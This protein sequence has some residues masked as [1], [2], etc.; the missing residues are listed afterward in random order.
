MEISA[1]L[2]KDLRDRTG[3]GM[4]DCKKAL[5]ESNGDLERAATILRERGIA[6]ASSKEGRATA[7]GV[8]ATYINQGDK[9]AVMVEVNCE[10]DF[11]A[12]TDQ[13]KAFARDVAVH[14][15]GQGQSYVK[16]NDA[17]LDNLVKSAIAQFGE[18]TQVKRFIRYQFT[19][20]VASYTHP[21][22]KLAVMVE[23]DCAN[24]S[25]VAKDEF[26]TFARDIA[27]HVAA[28][29][30]VCVKRDELDTSLLTKEREIYRQ[31]ALNDGKP[32][33]IVDKIV[34][35]RV[36]K[37]YGEVVLMEQPYVKDN[38]KTIT[39]LVKSA[40]AQFGESVQIKRFIRYRLG[41]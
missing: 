31:Q 17:A 18:N 28:T 29:N 38:D 9:L 35:G 12:R 19:G 32:A 7:E 34:D 1:S 5:G 26:K 30:P 22:D 21:G 20:G 36:E 4:M 13:F 25:I 11:V 27:M 2:V 15:I 10:T 37:Y 33:Q 6:K 8:I 39:D 16:E 24:Q 41:E 3:A 14:L 23:V 40:I